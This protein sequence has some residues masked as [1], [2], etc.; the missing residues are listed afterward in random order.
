MRSS[1]GLGGSRP[2]C[3]DVRT[4]DGYIAANPLRA[5]MVTDP[6]GYRWSSFAHHGLGRAGPLVSGFPDSQVAGDATERR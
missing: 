2:G 5:E 3:P 4:Y 6:A 1:R